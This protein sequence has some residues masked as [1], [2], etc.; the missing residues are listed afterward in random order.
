[1]EKK[2]KKR[3]GKTAN[4]SPVETSNAKKLNTKEAVTRANGDKKYIDL[5]RKINLLMMEN[6][7]V[8]VQIQELAREKKLNN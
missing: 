1:M 2:I 5:E 8:K 6:A 7:Q 3:S 4:L